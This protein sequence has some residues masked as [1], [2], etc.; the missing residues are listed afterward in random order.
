VAEIFPPQS[1]QNGGEAP[2]CCLYK[3]AYPG[4]SWAVD[5]ELVWKGKLATH[6]MPSHAL[7]SMVGELVTLNEYDRIGDR[8]AVVLY[9]TE[10]KLIRSYHIDEIVPKEDQEAFPGH[11]GGVYCNWNDG[12]RYFFTRGSHRLY[13]LLRTEKVVEFSLLSGEYRFDT[14]ASFPDLA[15][16]VEKKHADEETKIWETSL[17]FSSITDVL[18]AGGYRDKSHPNQTLNPS[19]NGGRDQ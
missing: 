10:G 13:I 6:Q 15:T 16:L 19:G 5:A 2:I 12:A 8:N 11:P 14:L 18:E 4:R 7:V 9:N 3:I 1:R 17:R